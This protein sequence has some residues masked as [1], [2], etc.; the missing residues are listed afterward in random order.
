MNNI[1]LCFL[2]HPGYHSL[3]WPCILSQSWSPYLHSVDIHPPHCHE[4]K[5]SKN[6]FD[7]PI[8]DGHPWKIPHFQQGTGPVHST[9]PQETRLSPA[10]CVPYLAYKKHCTSDIISHIGTFAQNA[11]Y[12]LSSTLFHVAIS[13]ASPSLTLSRHFGTKHPSFMLSKS[14]LPVGQETLVGPDYVN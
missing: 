4:N 7:Y 9:L 12:P 2:M 13:C 6:T 8:L 3:A 11:P 10:L 1:F 5:L 14:T